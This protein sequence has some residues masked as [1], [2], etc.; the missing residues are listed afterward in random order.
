[1]T[2][3]GNL[4][5]SEAAEKLG[6]TTEQVY[7]RIHSG[8]LRATHKNLWRQKYVIPADAIR[9]YMD[10]GGDVA[11]DMLPMLRVAHVCQITGFSPE[12]VR[13]LIRTGQL[14]AVRGTG[15]NG[16]YRITRDSV[17]R[18]LRAGRPAD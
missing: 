14:D 13:E 3:T 11:L 9:E 18:Y 2:D 10:A 1:M 6:L 4:S 8:Q 16:H 17:D 15:K 5:V 12:T 7:R